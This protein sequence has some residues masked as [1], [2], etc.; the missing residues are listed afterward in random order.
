[1]DIVSECEGYSPY[2]INLSSI[3]SVVLCASV[4]KIPFVTRKSSL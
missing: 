4:V 3:F 1:M 2:S